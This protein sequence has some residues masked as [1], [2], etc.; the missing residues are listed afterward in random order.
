MLRTGS[1]CFNLLYST[2][3]SNDEH[4]ENNIDNKAAHLRR[5]SI[6]F[7]SYGGVLGKVAQI[8]SLDNK[9]SEVYSQCK[10]ALSGETTTYFKNHVLSNT[11]Y[12]KVDINYEV[13][14]AGSVGQVHKCIIDS[15]EAIVKVQYYGLEDQMKT[16]LRVLEA[17]TT[18]MFDF[19][20]LAHALVEV[21]DKLE[22]ELDYTIELKNMNIMRE[23]W[24]SHPL[25]KIPRPIDEL[26]CKQVIAMEFIDGETLEGFIETSTQEQKNNIGYM[27]IE[28]IFH[29]MFVNHLLYS[30]IHYGNFIIKDK[31]QLY[32]T[33]FGCMHDL[34]PKLVN[35]LKDI[36]KSLLENN[37]INFYDAVSSL[38]VL[39]DS[40]SNESKKYMYEFFK[41]QFEPWTTPT[42][43]EFTFEWLKRT[44]TKENELLKDWVLPANCIY[45]HKITY[46]MYHLLMNLKLKGDFSKVIEI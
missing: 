23:L 12:D 11:A 17:L 13:F 43:F 39:T 45:L 42:E 25:I 27:I 28:F 34:D 4:S 7:S 35:D 30:D 26:S 16:D 8:L 18:Y 29:N 44:A 38:G 21:K 46:G 20:D 32:V 5:L 1:L 14:K 41:L 22:E 19:A 24:D 40:V 36:Y 3:F 31:T 15:T 10:S 33:D 2:I 9:N 37:E 6:L